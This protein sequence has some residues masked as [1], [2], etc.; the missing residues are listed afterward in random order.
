[1]NNVIFKELLIADIEAKK[2]KVIQFGKNKNLLTSASNHLGKSL[3]CKALYYTL[4]AE[5]FFSD[6]WKRV[7]AIYQLS[8]TVQ[9]NLYRV[10]RKDNIFTVYEPQG[11]IVKLFKTKNFSQYINTLFG[12]DTKIRGRMK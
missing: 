3:I 4:G 1:M 9:N 8:F 6:A 2:A 7:N 11:K 5:T 10:V 12:L